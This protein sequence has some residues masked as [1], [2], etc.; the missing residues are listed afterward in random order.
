VATKLA[1]TAQQQVAQPAEGVHL[2][3]C[4]YDVRSKWPKVHC[5]SPA[6]CQSSPCECCSQLPNLLHAQM[7]LCEGCQ[8]DVLSASRQQDETLTNNKQNLLFICN[9]GGHPD[10]QG[11]LS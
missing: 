2:L 9:T 5:W 3:A 4:E 11:H 1:A 6:A 7:T 8:A 10:D